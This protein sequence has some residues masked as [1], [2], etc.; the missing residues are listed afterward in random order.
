GALSINSPSKVF[1]AAET[2]D[3]LSVS[4][5]AQLTV[6]IR[7]RL[8]E[9]PNVRTSRLEAIQSQFDSN[10]YRPDIEIIVDRLLR[11]HTQFSDH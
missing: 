10:T 1:G 6:E 7:G 8:A 3:V 11:E 5:T 9:I 4:P 2:N